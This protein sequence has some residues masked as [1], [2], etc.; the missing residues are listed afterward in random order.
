MTET[1]SP[2]PARGETAGEALAR[3]LAENDEDAT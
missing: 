3:V 2:S 1:G